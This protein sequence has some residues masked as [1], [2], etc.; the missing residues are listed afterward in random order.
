VGNYHHTSTQTLVTAIFWEAFSAASAATALAGT[1]FADADIDMLGVLAGRA[2]DLSGFLASIGVP[3]VD[4]TYY[5][6]CF[7][8]GA[9]LLLVRA[10]PWQE[11]IAIAVIR[12]HGGMLSP[13]YQ[14]HDRRSPVTCVAVDGDEFEVGVQ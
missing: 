5:N 9:V 8:D 3:D 11:Q 1:G 10:Q 4:A 2:P 14:V 12:R 7:Q 13:S 6:D